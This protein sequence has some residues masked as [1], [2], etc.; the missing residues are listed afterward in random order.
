[1]IQSAAKR[2]AIILSISLP[3]LLVGVF[4]L[5]SLIDPL[6]HFHGNLITGKNYGYNERLSKLNLF[7]QHPEKYDCYIF[8]SSR[9]TLLDS[10]TIKGHRCFNFA[11]SGGEIGEIAAYAA[12]LSKRGHE[13]DFVIV[14]VDGFNFFSKDVAKTIPEHIRK[15]LT[16][17]GFLIDYLT[18][19]ALEF[20]LRTLFGSSPLLPRYYDRDF[21][22]S[23]LT[24][25][26]P[27]KPSAKNTDGR[28]KHFYVKNTEWYRR[29]TR[30]FRDAKF[31]FYVPPISVW[32]IREL[33]RGNNL[34]DYL[35]GI[36]LVSQIAPVLYDF[37]IPSD[38]TTDNSRTYDGSH[39]DLRTNE[40]I[41]ETLSGAAT[42]FGIEPKRLSYDN[43]KRR[44]LDVLNE[45][46][47]TVRRRDFE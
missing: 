22:A 8:G 46:H 13:P 42:G 25:T 34:D 24:D 47:V 9:T 31:V 27:Y 38:I 30:A 16:P 6:W 21:S 19:D 20:S 12:Y 28:S 7:L 18:V 4:A 40:L 26:P 33:E 15:N 3:V 1:M 11:F 2:Y 5:N 44:Y 45:Q 35:S 23:I 17:P 37:A 36:Y 43:Y 14:G 10:K 32:K 41:A 29:L 39:F